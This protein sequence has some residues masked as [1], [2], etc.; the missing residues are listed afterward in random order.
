MAGDR[1]R[2][3]GVPQG[4]GFDSSAIRQSYG[5]RK[6]E[7]VPSRPAKPMVLARALGS[8]PRLS[9][10]GPAGAVAAQSL[11]KGKVVGSIPTSGTITVVKA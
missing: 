3:P 10:K 2:K 5:R 9:A 7:G 1:S 6:R 4:S 8:N 11:G